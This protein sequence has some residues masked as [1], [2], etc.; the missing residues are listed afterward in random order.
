MKLVPPVPPPWTIEKD[1]TIRSYPDGTPV[2]GLVDKSDDHEAFI[3]HAAYI[4]YCVN[5]HQ[6]HEAESQ[7]YEAE[8]QHLSN[9]KQLLMDRLKSVVEQLKSNRAIEALAALQKIYEEFDE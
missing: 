8:I 1:L 2:V 6:L 3:K 7:L 5:T 4:V 9:E